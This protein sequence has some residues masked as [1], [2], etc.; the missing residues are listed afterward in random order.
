M[1]ALT[2]TKIGVWRCSG[3]YMLRTGRSWTFTAGSVTTKNFQ[4]WMPIE[5]ADKTSDCSS[6]CQTSAAMVRVGSNLRVA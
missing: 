1:H 4:G 2:L 3:R 6:A 5:E